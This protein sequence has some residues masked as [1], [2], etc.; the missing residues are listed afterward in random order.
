MS[1][2]LAT[3]VRVNLAVAIA[4]AAVLALRLPLRHLFGARATYGLWILVPAAAA[5]MLAPPRVV[6][7]MASQPDI[8]L[9]ALPPPP[10]SAGVVV[11]QAIDPTP[12]LLALWAT[13]A[14][15]CA[16]W[17]G[18]RQ[19]QFGR[20]ARAGR[21]G[22][23][24]IGVLRPRIVLPD[25][26]EARYSLREQLVILA[27]ERTH[28]A[29]GDPRINALA[30]AGSCL[31]W[32]N[33]FAH[34]AVRYLR[35]D[36]E[37]ACDAAVVAAHPAA[38]RSY[39]EAMLKTQ[40]AARPLP[41]GCYWPAAAVH[42]LTERIGLLARALPSRRRRQA[43]GAAVALLALGG[44][45]GGWTARPPQVEVRMDAPA[46]SPERP[47]RPGPSIAAP[48][49]PPPS[50]K[51]VAV[52]PI[53]TATTEAAP[54]LAGEPLAPLAVESPEPAVEASR[55]IKV[56]KAAERSFV[57]PGSA[58]RVMASMTDADGR[59]LV[60]DLTAF[61]SQSAY[62]IGRIERDGSRHSL[63]TS[64]EQRGH[65]LLVSASLGSQFEPGSSGT[66][67]LASGQ[68]RTIVLGDG[69]AVTVTATLRPETAD[70]VEEGRRFTKRLPERRIRTAVI[71][72]LPNPFRC[73][74][75]G[76]IC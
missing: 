66:I 67:P 64:V 44:G 8:A 33:P 71:A 27:H 49:V 29:R 19:L 23:A 20:A 17:L 11:T 56:H 1:E 55:R 38:R 59:Q 10:V 12:A 14:L 54:S 65:T 35:I 45:V 70:E 53:E 74:R 31:A 50:P 13:G 25:D 6:T 32:F 48:A 47:I 73:G 26:F 7:V 43:G 52:A 24:V 60:T 2:A 22:P 69:E 21:A 75:R 62:R 16:L 68:T 3:L 9:P 39:A 57:E 46:A 34:L 42:P 15:A 72:P 41:L 36:Q 30:A 4:V 28:I 58:V 61:G 5:A 37:L 76:A 51:R 40:L 18:V 63:F